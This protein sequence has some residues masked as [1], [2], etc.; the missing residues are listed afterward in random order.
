MSKR[1]TISPK[2]RK[3]VLERDNYK[4]RKCGI[5]LYVLLA[6]IHHIIPFSECEKDDIENLISLCFFCHACTPAESNRFYEWLNS[7]KID[8]DQP[9][10]S[11][12]NQ[13]FINNKEGLFEAIRRLCEKIKHKS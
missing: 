9:E 10:D 13:I 2:I 8:L 12:I 4:C 7:N 5:D 6:E 3:I 11:P 1:K